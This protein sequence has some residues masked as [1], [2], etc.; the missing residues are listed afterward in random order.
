M[1]PFES[2]SW[3]MKVRRTLNKYNLPS[4]YDVLTDPPGKAEWKSTVDHAVKSFWN[5]TLVVEAT[6]KSSL[7]HLNVSKLQIGVPHQL[8]STLS[9]NPREVKH[10]CTKARLLTNT[11]VL[12]S[13]RAKFNQYDVKETC[14]MCKKESETRCHFLLKCEKLE[15]P[16]RYYMDRL[17]TMLFDN[18]PSDV[19][20]KVL[21][22]QNLTV[23]L[24]LDSSH[25]TISSIIT[26][27]PHLCNDIEE[28]TRKLC[29]NLHVHR[30]MLLSVEQGR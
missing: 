30:S 24:I 1:K 28:I 7:K 19:V 21:N 2:N 18:C 3:F 17:S 25:P 6:S 26:I 14:V 13:N 15:Q 11:Y 4:I 27:T 5:D 12:Q 22:N 23:Q 10:A 16:R 29:F 9:T 20:R 8:W